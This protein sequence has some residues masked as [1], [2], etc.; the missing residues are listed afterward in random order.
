MNYKKG[1]HSIEALL[2]VKSTYKYTVDKN[3]RL[4]IGM[5]HVANGGEFNLSA[6]GNNNLNSIDKIR[7]TRVNLGVGIDYNITKMINIDLFAGVS[8]RRQY[9]L[10]DTFD[11]LYEFDLEESPFIQLGI[12]LTPPKKKN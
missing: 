2:P 3:E 12:T 6:P 9:D 8:M 7:Y 1:K 10:N 4:N 11:E 5:R